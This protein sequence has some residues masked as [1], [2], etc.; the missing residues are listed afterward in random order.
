[1]TF[2]LFGWAS[3]MQLT[4][5][6]L[7]KLQLLYY[8]VEFII[9]LIFQSWDPNWDLI[10]IW[11]FLLFLWWVF[12]VIGLSL[13]GLI[14]DEFRLSSY[15]YISCL[16]LNIIGRTWVMSIQL[17]ESRIAMW[18]IY[19]KIL[20]KFGLFDISCRILQMVVQ[21]C[22]SVD[23]FHSF[24]N[25][26][27]FISHKIISILIC[28]FSVMYYILNTFFFVHVEQVFNN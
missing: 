12:L 19:R 11:L 2:L 26:M 8:S 6:L 24:Q 10:L 28:I 9:I 16:F 25:F 13:H 7:L 15:L 18:R 23:N 20:A 14:V 17:F 4:T 21:R 27:K 3:A 5:Q 1:M 22:R